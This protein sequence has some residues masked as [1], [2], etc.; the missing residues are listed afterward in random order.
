MG[1]R[2]SAS[3]HSALYVALVRRDADQCREC[4]GTPA[5]LGVPRLTIDHVDGD[6]TDD[7]LD[8]LQLLC[9]SCNTAKRNRLQADQAAAWRS[10]LK[11]MSSEGPPAVMGDQAN[12]PSPGAHRP[13][14]GPGK[15]R[16]TESER[17]RFQRRRQEIGDQGASPEFRANRRYEGAWM[18]W[19]DLQLDKRGFIS[20]EDA[21]Y[22]GAARVD[23]QPQTTW[24]YVE[25]WTSFE[26]HL[27]KEE[28]D[29]GVSVIVRRARSTSSD[30]HVNTDAAFTEAEDDAERT[31]HSNG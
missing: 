29:A 6:R 15:G 22:A 21:I 7:S 11:L 19:L 2:F 20:V 28:D 9:R 24:R 13:H 10:H 4:G 25:K 23:C 18:D 3:R 1:N 12:E 30:P 14:G 26:G 8:N 16:R 17:W 31:S 5:T 27:L